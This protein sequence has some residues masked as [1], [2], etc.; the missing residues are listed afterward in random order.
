MYIK[1]IKFIKHIYILN[2]IKYIY[3]LYTLNKCNLIICDTSLND[4]SVND[5]FIWLKGT[6]H[7]ESSFR[8]NPNGRNFRNQK[9]R[10]LESILEMKIFYS[11]ITE[12]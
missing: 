4:S 9:Q 8:L 1:Y 10:K 11:L 2:L 5:R 12:L 7:R 3:L 6:L